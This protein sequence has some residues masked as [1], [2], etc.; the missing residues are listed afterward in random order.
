MKRILLIDDDP[1]ILA[2]FSHFLKNKGFDVVKAM[3]GNEATALLDDRSVDLI[4]T[5]IMMPGKDGVAF[6]RDIRAAKNEV[7][8]IAISGGTLSNTASVQQLTD[9]LGAT[10]LLQKP[11]A[12]SDLLVVVNEL[13]SM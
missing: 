5:D 3:D 13:L 8:I 6:I 10:R 2:L 7:P 11:I 12:L 1:P 4:I 9:R